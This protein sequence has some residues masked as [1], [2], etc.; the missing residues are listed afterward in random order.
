MTMLSK[1][2]PKHA[3][4]DIETTGLDP[5]HD[6]VIEVGVVFVADGKVV[7]TLS[8][9]LKPH[10]TLPLVI[11]R[12]TGLDDDTLSQKPTLAE[13]AATLQSA[14]K[15][16]TLVAHNASFERGFLNENVDAVKSPMLDTCELVH[17]LHPELRSHAL[18]A[19]VRHS[20]HASGIAHRAEQ[21][22]QDTFQ[23]LAS[24]LTEVVHKR[25]LSDVRDLLGTLSPIEAQLSL[26]AQL[27]P[28]PI[29]LLLERL[30]D[31]L[32]GEPQELK[33]EPSHS[34][35]PLRAER[36]RA[37]GADIE[38]PVGRQ[39]VP[40][41]PDEVSAL[42]G[43]GGALEQSFRGFEARSEQVSLA[44]AVARTLNSGGV[45]A[46]EAGTGI[47][48]SLAYLAPAALYAARNGVRIAVAPHTKNLQ[49]QLVDREL[50]R[51]HRATKGAFSY[52]VLKGQTNYLCRRRALEVTA[53][54][55]GM[56]WAERAPRAYL[57]AFLRRSP[58]GDL[59]AL[60]FWFKDHFP[61]LE[62]LAVSARSESSTTLG[63]K[64]PHYARCFYHSA[65]AQAASADVVVVNQSLALNWPP[66]YGPLDH[67]IVDEAHE[68]ED[69]ATS[70][71]TIELSQTSLGRLMQRLT[72]PRG[73]AGLLDK[74]GTPGLA[75]EARTLSARLLEDGQ[76]LKEAV[77]GL[78]H[79]TNSAEASFRI[80]A[81]T[82]VSRDWLKVRDG[83][84]GLDAT[85][86][87][88]DTLLSDTLREAL[89]QL[90][91]E[92]PAT[93]RELSG[94]RAAAQEAHQACE[95]LADRPNP[96][97]C[98]AAV[99]HRGFWSL[100]LQPIDIGPSFQTRFLEGK[101]S[102]VL[103]SATL[104]TGPDNPWVLERLGLVKPGEGGPPFF[105]LGTP[106][107]LPSQALV[108]LVT[109]APDPQSDAFLDWSAARISGLAH[110]LGGRLL[111][112]FASKHRLDEVAARAMQQLEPLGI[113]VLKQAKGAARV[114]AAQQEQDLGSVLLGTKS[115]WQGVDIPGP[116]VATVFIDKLPLEP[117][118]RPIVE[119]REERLG[120]E[121]LGFLGYRLPRAL[122]MLRQGVGRL[123]RSTR[124]R[125]VV[126]IADPGSPSY[127]AH[128][129]AALEGYRVEA[130]PWNQ[131][132]IRIYHALK[133][134]GYE[135]RAVETR[136][137]VSREIPVQGTLFGTG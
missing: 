23:V 58:D 111:G 119:A 64:C 44:L 16:W 11:R 40:V 105:R 36:R 1:L 63:S 131:A 75:Q 35:L 121:P 25:R 107:D 45:L 116:G 29:L 137:T 69:T 128:L 26:A 86:L 28:H 52:S 70:A 21:D 30:R 62:E 97:R 39:A 88:I 32:G 60:S 85:L 79:S 92:H 81:D 54:S 132:R 33:L 124:D 76:T 57:R 67:I 51:L 27:E 122:L 8:Q 114:L 136:R 56:G 68:L 135:A 65:V 123:I 112:L 94:T 37:Q 96:N 82:R 130:L 10:R 109:D 73:A 100:Q 2:L 80:S 103:A 49:D 17:Y 127:R 98:D 59:D 93:E 3:F 42:L 14:L 43:P 84:H 129:Y 41:A 110:F 83:L 18:D 46:A 74:I 55:E 134:M 71:W 101:R 15:G 72:G 50:P 7:K 126:V 24:V 99:M 91:N 48:K 12:L 89:P 19:L 118:G 31:V 113:E 5:K 38:L 4:L 20:G 9:L 115:F 61:A 133:A 22:A 53:V 108:I 47:G 6:E 66:R 102:V 13:Y 106:Y 95:E 77:A 87:A 34:F 117:Q 104:S 90:A 120:N 78:C 125:G